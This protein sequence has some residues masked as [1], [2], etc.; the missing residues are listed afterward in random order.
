[1]ITAIF[2]IG[3]GY[4]FG[5][6]NAIPWSCKEDLK[7]FK[8]TTTGST[9]IMGKNTWNSI[10]KTLFSKDRKC[11][12]VSTKPVDDDRCTWSHSLQDAIDVAHFFDNKIFIIGGKRLLIDAF[13]NNAIDNIILSKVHGRYLYDVSFVELKIYLRHFD[14]Y[15]LN[16]GETFD[17]LYYHLRK[18]SS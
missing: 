6:K 17:I 15:E 5:Y 4:E 16:V 2:A 3:E 9:L 11:I 10:P 12:V 8:N 14:L 7:H 18:C 1:M 13:E